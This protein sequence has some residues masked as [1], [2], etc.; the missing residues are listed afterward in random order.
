MGRKTVNKLPMNMSVQPS[1]RILSRKL[2]SAQWC[3]RKCWLS[4]DVT[5]N[6]DFPEFTTSGKDFKGLTRTPNLQLVQNL[7]VKGQTHPD[8]PMV[9]RPL[10]QGSLMAI[11]AV[12]KIISSTSTTSQHLDELVTSKCMKGLVEVGKDDKLRQDISRQLVQTPKKDVFFSW[13]EEISKDNQTMRVCAMYFPYYQRCKEAQ[14]QYFSAVE[15]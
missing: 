4:Q 11:E 12:T 9:S 8:D 3:L 13:I 2:Q 5:S 1:Y 7:L 6:Q 14:T 15:E 10:L